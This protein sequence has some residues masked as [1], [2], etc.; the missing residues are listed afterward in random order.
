MNTLKKKNK[1]IL[2]E[3]KNNGLY[4]DERL[5]ASQQSSKIDVNNNMNMKTEG[6][7]ETPNIKVDKNPSTVV[8]IGKVFSYDKINLI[9]VHL[10]INFIQ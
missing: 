3:I 9:Y 5:I 1:Q 7:V 2:T 10:L 4:K 6:P 8:T